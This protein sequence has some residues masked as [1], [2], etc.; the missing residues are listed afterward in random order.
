MNLLPDEKR[1]CKK[2]P[3]T[4]AASTS[5]G[6]LAKHLRVFH[7][8]T[9]DTVA[10]SSVATQRSI[11]DHLPLA[12][13]LKYDSAIATYVVSEVLPLVHVASLGLRSLV[14]YGLPLNPGHVGAERAS[15]LCGK[16]R[17]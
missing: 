6:T 8:I 13:K 17:L 16:A 12:A 9:Q 10:P 14:S 7:G 3:T 1:G 4:F 2:C 15:Q 11:T 5:T